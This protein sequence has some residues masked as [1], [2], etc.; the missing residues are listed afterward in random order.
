MRI[1][2][3]AMAVSV[4]LVGCMSDQPQD[5]SS[6]SCIIGG[7]SGELCADQPLASVCLWREV[8]VCY[9]TALCGRQPD[10]T[11]GWNPTP[12]LTACIAA[13]PN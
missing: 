5:P 6:G 1:A 13:N 4:V 7:C 8:Y 3:V 9:K 12:E 10:G 11:C 2:L